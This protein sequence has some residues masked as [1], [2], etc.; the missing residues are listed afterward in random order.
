MKKKSSRKILY[1][2][3]LELQDELR[4]KEEAAA[5]RRQLEIPEDAVIVYERSGFYEVL[6]RVGYL[7]MLLLVLL[8]M[9]CAVIAVITVL[10]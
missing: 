3:Y 8:L 10:L 6:R 9:G 4:E 5:Q 7:L 1:Q 2:R